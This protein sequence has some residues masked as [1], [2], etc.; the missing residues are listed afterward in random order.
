MSQKTCLFLILLLGSAAAN[1]IFPGV[2]ES[3]ARASYA[4]RFDA[5]GAP[6]NHTVGIPEAPKVAVYYFHNTVRCATCMRMED[7]SGFAIQAGFPN[8]LKSGKIEWRVV[9]MQ[10]PENRHFAED[11]KLHMSSLVIVRFKDGKQVEWRN[12]EKIW[13]HVGDITDFVKYVQSNVRAFLNAN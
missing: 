13:D 3:G 2:R 10:M 1:L 12:L 5:A 11:F 9:N 7:Y 4:S 8:E 6:T